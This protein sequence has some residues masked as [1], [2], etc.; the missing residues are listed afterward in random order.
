MSSPVGKNYSVQVI[1]LRNVML[2][3]LVKLNFRYY[4]TI[5]I[6]IHLRL[7]ICSLIVCKLI[8][9]EFILLY[10]FEKNGHYF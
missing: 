2:W 8:T 7:G 10:Y 4:N 9:N 3:K 6:I 5:V 1:K